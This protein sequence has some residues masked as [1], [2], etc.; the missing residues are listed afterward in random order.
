[1]IKPF[2]V[3]RPNPPGKF[4]IVEEPIA[5]VPYTVRHQ[6][7]YDRAKFKTEEIPTFVQ[8]N[9]PKGWPIL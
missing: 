4:F 1:M 7:V 6:W 2:P 8:L 5:T 9:L 3:V